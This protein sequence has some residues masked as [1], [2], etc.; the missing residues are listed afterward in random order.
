M[1]HL[2]RGALHAVDHAEGRHQLA[3]GMH[4]HLEL[5]AAHVAH[6]LREHLGGAEDGVERFREAGGEA[7]ADR[8]LGVHDGR[9]GA[10]SQ[11]AGDAGTWMNER[12]S[13]RI[14]EVDARE[15]E[16][17]ARIQEGGIGAPP[18]I[19]PPQ[20]YSAQGAQLPA[21]FMRSTRIE[22]VVLAPLV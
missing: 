15:G 21:S 22:P 17:S 14:S 7:P 8:G 11:H 9:C 16:S 10:C 1:C 4:R 13:M 2:D 3:R 18:G 20:N 19:F 12:R 6:L 5:A